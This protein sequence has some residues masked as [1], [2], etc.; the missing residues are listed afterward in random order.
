[1]KDE[2]FTMTSAFHIQQNVVVVSTDIENNRDNEK[3]KANK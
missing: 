1:M 2:N 3:Y